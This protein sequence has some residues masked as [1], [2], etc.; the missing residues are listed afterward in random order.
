MQ[1]F[2]VV[3]RPLDFV[4]TFS[5][6]W[7]YGVAFGATANKVMFLFSEG[8][9]PLEV[10]QWAQGTRP[11]SHIL[12]MSPGH[13]CSQ[14]P[15]GLS[16]GINSVSSHI[17]LGLLLTQSQCL[18]AHNTFQIAWGNFPQLDSEVL[19][20]N[21]TKTQEVASSSASPLSLLPSNRH[22]FWGFSSRKDAG[23]CDHYAIESA[24]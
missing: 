10:P 11:T 13:T 23:F 18:V 1:H 24:L 2:S 22:S 8:Y 16:G 9:Q 4:G 5:N 19:W 15:R 3:Y 20:T 6:R 12:G 21:I 17:L 7:S 14:R